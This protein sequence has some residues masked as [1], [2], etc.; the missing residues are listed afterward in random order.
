MVSKERAIEILKETGVL[1]EGHFLYT[2]GRHGDK[3]FQCA[4]IFQYPWHSEEICKG[5]AEKFEDDG[6]DLVVGPAVGAVIMSYEMSR[7]LGVRNLFAERENGVM[8][9]RRGF[10]IEKGAR[11]LVV[12]DVVTTG[13]STREVMDVVRS[14]GAE[15]AGV[16]CI[17]DRTGGKV[18]FGMKFESVVSLDVVSYSPEECPLC[19]EGTPYIKPGSRKV[20]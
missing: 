1:L 14:M 13:G 5:L 6:I 19:K 20:G 4:R 15:I 16:G 9:L 8:T 11:V 10:E 18:D 2:S 3:Y 7:H 12:E 17:V